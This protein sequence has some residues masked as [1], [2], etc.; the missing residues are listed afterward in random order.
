[1]M[2]TS[3]VFLTIAALMGIGFAIPGT[4]PEPRDGGC[5]ESCDI[6]LSSCITWCAEN[7][8]GN[9]QCLEDCDIFYCD[10]PGCNTCGTCSH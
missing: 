2:H 10:Q 3:I 9:N 4:H 5:P 1:M 7:G 6:F 8:E